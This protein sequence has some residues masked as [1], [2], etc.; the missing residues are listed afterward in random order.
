MDQASERGDE[1]A[2][3][4]PSPGGERRSPLDIITIPDPVLRQKT[5]P[6]DRFTPALR[7]L[8]REMLA[9]MHEAAGVGL[10]APQVGL[11]QR[12]FVM[13]VKEDDERV[14]E[15]HPL[16]GKPLVLV[17]PEIVETSEELEEG[18]EACLSIPDYG[19][20][21]PRHRRVV[22]QARNE[23]G[24]PQRYEVDEFLARVMQHEID[25]L[26]GI[27]FLDR[28]TG[29]DKLFKVTPKDE[30]S[31]SDQESEEVAD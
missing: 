28:L 1:P 3:G 29:D 31:E 26:D 7:S 4:P 18:L 5:L 19:G 13:E 27:L 12:L 15:D 23:W 6:V 10:A 30:T 17:N 8:A 25:H 14:P 11:L 21:V 22:I 24:K 2:V 16:R 9:T 20:L